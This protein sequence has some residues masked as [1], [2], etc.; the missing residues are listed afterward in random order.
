[1]VAEMD[2]KGKLPLDMDVACL[3][4]TEEPILIVGCTDRKVQLWTLGDKVS[5]N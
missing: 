3:P 4:G 5:V 2:M 1:M